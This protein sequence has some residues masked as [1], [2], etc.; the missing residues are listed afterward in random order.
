MSETELIS[1][2]VQWEPEEY[3]D[4]SWMKTDLEDGKIID[5]WRY[6]QEEYDT[7]P[8]QVQQWIDE[9][10]QR[11]R[12]FGSSWCMMGCYAEAQVK[13]TVNPDYET[14]DTIRSYGLWGI[15]SDSDANYKKEV[16]AEQLE[17]LKA[18]LEK[19]GVDTTQF[20]HLTTE[21]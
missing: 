2:K 16:E 18:E 10:H 11:L 4:L 8:K 13:I 12:E 21:N 7:N 6:T 9:D 5:S 19:R 20:N 3:P 1:V 17:D 15:E 14:T